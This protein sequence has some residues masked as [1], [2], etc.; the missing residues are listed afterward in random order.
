MLPRKNRHHFAGSIVEAQE[1]EYKLIAVQDWLQDRDVVLSS[2]L[3]HDMTAE[4]LPDLEQVSVKHLCSHL[5]SQDEMDIRAAPAA[6]LVQINFHIFILELHGIPP[7]TINQKFCQGP[8]GC[9]PLMQITI[10]HSRW[11]HTLGE[12]NLAFEIQRNLRSLFGFVLMGM[13]DQFYSVIFYIPVMM[14]EQKL[15]VIDKN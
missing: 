2:H 12:K 4:T 14:S 3:E 6:S 9:Q 7:V 1:W 13:I 5:S 15:F 11:L 10:T 8:H